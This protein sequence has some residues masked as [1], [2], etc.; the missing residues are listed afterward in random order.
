MPARPRPPFLHEVRGWAEEE[1]RVECFSGRDSTDVVHEGR[2]VGYVEAPTV[3]VQ[4]D[5]GRVVHWVIGLVRRKTDQPAD[6]E[7]TVEEVADVIDG[8]FLVTFSSVSREPP[9]SIAEHLLK[10]YRITPRNEATFYAVNREAPWKRIAAHPWLPKNV[11][12]HLPRLHGD[13]RLHRWILSRSGRR[14]NPCMLDFAHPHMMS[15][16]RIVDGVTDF[17]L[18]AGPHIELWAYFGAYDHVVL[19]QLFG[20][21]MD[22]PH[23]VPMFTHELMQEWIRAG[24]PADPP[25]TDEHNALADAKWNRA[26]Y[27]AITAA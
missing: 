1:A 8:A 4:T 17:I 20:T 16:A 23:G 24:Q 3:V 11:V 26:L 15:R 9:R 27:G 6:A 10:R 19:A 12:A 22:L 2:I 14:H 7:A 18:R 21:M 25:H 13:E 5:D